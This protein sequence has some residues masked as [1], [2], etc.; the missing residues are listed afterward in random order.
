VKINGYGDKVHVQFTNFSSEGQVTLDIYD[1][2]GRKV[3][4]TRTVATGN[5]SYEVNVPN[6]V[7]GFYFSVLSGKDYQKTEKVFLTTD[8]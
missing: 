1:I 7:S 8:K 4:D 2:M 3:I 6:V 5:S